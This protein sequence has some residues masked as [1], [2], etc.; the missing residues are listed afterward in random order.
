MGR[1]EIDWD[2]TSRAATGRMQCAKVANVQLARE[3]SAARSSANA[4]RFEQVS[5][6]AEEMLAA[7]ESGRF[8]FKQTAAAAKPPVRVAAA[9]GGSSRPS[10]RGRSHTR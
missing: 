5:A 6:V 3:E 8:E 7:G 10:S 2:G 1:A 9:D 4:T